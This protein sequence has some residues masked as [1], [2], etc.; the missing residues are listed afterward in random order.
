MKRIK[1][2]CLILLIIFFGSL[3]QGAVLPFVEGVKYGFAVARYEGDNK[4]STDEFLLMDIIAKDAS[5]METN[6]LNVKTGEKA[7]LR[8]NN[9]SVL[10]HSLPE[11]PV[12][13]EILQVIYGILILF[14]LVLGVWIPFLVVKILRSL[15]HSE[16]FDRI[17]LK[18]INRIGVF[19]LIM[20]IFGTLIQLINV[21]SAQ[22]MVDLTHYTFSY[23][24]VIDFDALIMAVVILI[25][26]EVLR[27]A[28]EIKEEQDLTI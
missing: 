6:E 1:T 21:V 5:Y 3:Y 15:Q 20:A 8:L 18:R 16:V 12:W 13:W 7:L 9:V 27:I 14:S 17:N 10:V 2:L 23:A 25:M 22:Y 28:I 26:N 4:K 19:L 24:K 11:K